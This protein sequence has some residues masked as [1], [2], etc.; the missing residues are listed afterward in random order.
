[1]FT[2]PLPHQMDRPIIS[3]LIW[4]EAIKMNR[5]VMLGVLARVCLELASQVAVLVEPSV[6]MEFPAQM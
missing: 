4:K 3:M 5:Y 1:M 6:T 2:T